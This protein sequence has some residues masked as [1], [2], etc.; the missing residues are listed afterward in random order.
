MTLHI[1][2]VGA[3]PVGLYTAIRLCEESPTAKVTVYE[4]RT[5]PYTRQH[6]VDLGS[7]CPIAGIP[8]RIRLQ[9]LETILLK[10]ANQFGTRLRVQTGRSVEMLDQVRG[11][12]DVVIAADGAHSQLRNWHKCNQGMA[13]DEVLANIIQVKYWYKCRQSYSK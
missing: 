1:A 12:A 6:S 3:G 9:D 13:R 5:G 4:K 10:R 8:T 11:S 2:V 7:D